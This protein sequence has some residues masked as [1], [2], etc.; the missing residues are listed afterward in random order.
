M[1]RIGNAPFECWWIVF[2]LFD[3]ESLKADRFWSYTIGAGRPCCDFP[4]KQS[5]RARDHWQSLPALISFI[6]DTCWFFFVFS[7]HEP[8]VDFTEK[9]LLCTNVY[10]LV[11]NKYKELSFIVGFH[12][13]DWRVIDNIYL[14]IVQESFINKINGKCHTKSQTKCRVRV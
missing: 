3:R 2:F 8:G 14:F 9:Q 1:W 5:F 7:V 6:F 4:L 13:F 12:W 11:Y 10:T